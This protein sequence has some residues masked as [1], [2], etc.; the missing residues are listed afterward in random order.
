[1]FIVLEIFIY[2]VMSGL[3]LGMFVYAWNIVIC[4]PDSKFYVRTS[5]HQLTNFL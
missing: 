2:I 4:C 5:V 3:S 1:M